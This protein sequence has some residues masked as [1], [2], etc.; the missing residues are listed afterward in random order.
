VGLADDG[1][2]THDFPTLAPC[3]ASSTDFLQPAKGRGQLF[4]LGQGALAGGLTRAI[5]IEDYPL[6]AHSIHQTACLPLFR[7]RATEQI[8]KKECA[9][10]FDWRLGQSRQKARESRAGW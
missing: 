10:S 4:C 1:A 6:E 2:G 7:E 8:V 3:V 9:Q 5:D